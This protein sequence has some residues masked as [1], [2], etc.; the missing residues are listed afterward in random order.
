MKCVENSLFLKSEKKITYINQKLNGK[1][2]LDE[3][4]H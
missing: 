2:D 1:I 4:Q 3:W